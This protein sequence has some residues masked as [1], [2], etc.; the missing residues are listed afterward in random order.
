MSLVRYTWLFTHLAWLASATPSYADLIH[1]LGGWFTPVTGRDLAG[2]GEVYRRHAE[3]AVQFA[4]S[5]TVALT[6]YV[7]AIWLS[8]GLRGRAAAAVV[9][10]G[11]AL[12][13]VAGVLAPDM[14]SQDIFSYAAYGQ[15]LLVRGAN[16]YVHVPADFADAVYLDFVFW[17]HVPSFYGPL[18][19]LISAGVV[20]L[21]GDDVAGAVLLFRAIQA[22]AA[23]VGTIL[24]L[25]V[26][27]QLDPRRALAG[28]VIFGWNPLLVIE[29]GLSGHNDVVMVTLIVLAVA[30]TVWRRGA[31]ACAAL[32]AAGLIK[33]TALVLLPLLGIY[34][35]RREPTWRAR[36]RLVTRS[37][38][39]S[40]PLAALVVAPVWAGPATLAVGALGASPD[41]YVNS[42]GELALGEL[43]AYYGESREDLAIPLQFRGWWVATHTPTALMSRPDA[44]AV[45]L[46]AVDQWQELL[47]VAPERWHWMKV[48]DPVTRQIGYVSAADVGPIERPPW[49]ELDPQILNL[50]AGPV[51][52]ASLRRANRDIRTAGWGAFVVVFCAGLVLGTG[53]LT[54]LLRTW[55][56]LFSVLFYAT[57]TW[58]WPWYALWALPAAA[59]L[60]RSA[61]SRFAVLFSWGVL[62]IY[63]GLGFQN[64][65]LWYVQTYRAIPAF[66]LPLAIWL[67]ESGVRGAVDGARR[68]LPPG[69]PRLSPSRLSEVR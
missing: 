56:I 63:V 66:G 30:L 10:V 12:F 25:R 52:T 37:G 38:L 69:S 2:A 14:L 42:L 4:L 24:V 36:A 15:M 67:A 32:V 20:G 61:W 3:A 11:A 34:L 35:L 5:V 62:L 17:K 45:P 21:T 44:L 65:N 28:A 64:T 55:M 58:F 60:P 68:L 23:V 41:R 48:F 19:T 27:E 59:L 9:I 6:L 1:G 51:G 50:E 22:V 54:A 40:L 8:R 47:L 33:V 43:R 57:L 39:V 7:A 31:L 53:S 16:P 46:A 18:W 13:Q 26:L 29:G 49:A